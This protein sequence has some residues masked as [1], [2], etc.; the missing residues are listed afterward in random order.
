MQLVPITVHV[1]VSC[2]T[3]KKLEDLLQRY[4]VST[5]VGNVRALIDRDIDKAL[6]R[7]R[8]EGGNVVITWNPDPQKRGFIRWSPNPSD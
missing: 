6:S 5:A 7:G 3:N 1:A 4:A 2:Y 8:I